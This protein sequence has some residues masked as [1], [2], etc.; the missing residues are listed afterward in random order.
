M[1]YM[2]DID[3]DK[4]RNL[5]W[6]HI[7]PFLNWSTNCSVTSKGREKKE[8]REFEQK[9]KKNKGRENGNVLRMLEY[10]RSIE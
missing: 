9:N 3:V 7:H 10:S 8:N 1:V 4:M 2:L 5:I 6:V